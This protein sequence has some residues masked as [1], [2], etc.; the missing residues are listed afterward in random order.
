V[1]LDRPPACGQ[2]IP[3]ASNEVAPTILASA[4]GP[5]LSQGAAKYRA[6]VKRDT[7]SRNGHRCVS[8]MPYIFVTDYLSELLP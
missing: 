8:S 4:F 7:L 2:N 6:C 3:L 5:Q 1:L